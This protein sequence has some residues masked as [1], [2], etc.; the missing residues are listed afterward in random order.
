[1]FTYEVYGAKLSHVETDLAA[2][3]VKVAGFSVEKL[4][5]EVRYKDAKEQLNAMLCEFK[6]MKEEFSRTPQGQSEQADAAESDEPIRIKAA[7]RW[8]R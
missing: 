3:R 8:H 1:M 7:R 5:D 4:I 6:E 2:V